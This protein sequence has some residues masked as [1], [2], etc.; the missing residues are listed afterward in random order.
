VGTSGNR[1]GRLLDSLEID[2]FG[3]QQVL[4]QI[5]QMAGFRGTVA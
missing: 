1:F 3:H 2:D 4:W 5:N